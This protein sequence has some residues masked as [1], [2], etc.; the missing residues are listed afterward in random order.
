MLVSFS[1]V[2]VADQK[3][4]DE[5]DWWKPRFG[6]ATCLGKAPPLEPERI[7]PARVVF[8]ICTAAYTLTELSTR[9]GINKATL[10]QIM[11]GEIRD[12]DYLSFRTIAN[13][14]SVLRVPMAT[15]FV[16][17]GPMINNERLDSFMLSLRMATIRVA[18]KGNRLSVRKRMQLIAAAIERHKDLNDDL[19][20]YSP[21]PGVVRTQKCLDCKGMPKE[22]LRDGAPDVALGLPPSKKTSKRPGRRAEQ[23][24]AEMTAILRSFDRVIASG[25]T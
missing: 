2:N 23:V 7:N 12:L 4:T 5:V 9:S 1:G 17:S 14:A 11:T 8:C 21:P 15:F 20:Y 6:P 16:G 13:L 25:D 19:F 10:S 24:A 3:T 22:W 18:L